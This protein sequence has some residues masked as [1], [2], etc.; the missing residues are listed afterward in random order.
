MATVVGR[1]DTDGWNRMLV[2]VGDEGAEFSENSG[3]TD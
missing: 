1:V 3:N 2:A